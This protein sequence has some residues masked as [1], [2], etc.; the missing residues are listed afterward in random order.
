MVSNSAAVMPAW[1]AIINCSMPLVPL[2][3]NPLASPERAD[4]KG[5]FVLHSGFRG[6]K[7]LSLSMTNMPWK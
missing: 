4:R 7:A 6:A 1:V 3:A 5:S 2:A